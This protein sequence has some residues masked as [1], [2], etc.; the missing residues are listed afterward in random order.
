MPDSTNSLLSRWIGPATIVSKVAENSYSVLCDDGSIKTLH[1]DK[2]RPFVN[3][4]ANVGIIFDD[5]DDNEFGS[6]DTCVD[7]KGNDPTLADD[8]ERFDQI[9]L[10]HLDAC[11]Q[12][13]LRDLL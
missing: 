2:L 1:A 8:R 12:K 6:I 10:S 3:R 4:I 11:K 9:D 13:Q 7:V 5:S